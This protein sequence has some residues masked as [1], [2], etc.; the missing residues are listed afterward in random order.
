MTL[1]GP[2][3]QIRDE[4]PPAFQA[5][6][7]GTAFV[8]GL[9]E[10]G[11][12]APTAVT[13]LAAYR[14]TF[15]ARV[16]FGALYDWA[17]VF[18]R[19]GGGRLW[20]RRVVGDAAV[21]SDVV[22]P[23]SGSG[24]PEAFLVSA[25][26]P[27]D[28]GDGLTVVVA[29]GIGA[30]TFKV[31]VRLDG[32]DMEVSADL[33]DNDELVA[34]G[35][36]STLVSFVKSGEEKPDNG[37]YALTGG[38]DD[39]AA[40]TEDDIVAALEDFVPAHGPGQLAV[41][42]FTS[43]AVHIG[44]LTHVETGNRV[45][46]LDL[47]D[48]SSASVLAADVNAV[49]IHNGS[50][51][52]AAF[53]PHVIVPGI[54]AGTTRTVPYSAVQAGMIARLDGQSDNPNEAAAGLGGVS[55]VA[56]GLSQPAWD[57][58]DREALNDA[59]VNVGRMILGDLR[60]YGYRTIVNS[61]TDPRWVEFSGSRVIMAILAECYSVAESFEFRQIDGRGLTIADFGG[62]LTAICTE[63]YNDGALYG[64]TPADAFNVDITTPNTPESIAARELHALIALRTSP[65]A[66]RVVVELVRRM[67][68]ETVV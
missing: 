59:G 15:G 25:S 7:T 56:L 34:W 50:R 19:E 43:D 30:G 29:N 38:D 52:G 64:A 24:D 9:T 5:F 40:V 57:A 4:A 1:P 26:S 17:D 48:S 20:I 62:E 12:L 65:F 21:V 14:K 41:P 68:T 33:A 28:W 23:H 47:Q 35:Q 22:L 45:A 42:G 32:V 36:S 58:T 37:T 31:T 67:V 16:A 39:H 63:H 11:P 13:S 54:A 66:E 49:K 3:V 27:G 55:R 2:D 10:R 61:I 51:Y 8:V 46:L 44:M 53:A 60:T 18:F 6:D